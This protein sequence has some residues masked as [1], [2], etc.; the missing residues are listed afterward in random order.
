M[1]RKKRRLNVE[2]LSTREMTDILRRLLGKKGEVADVVRA[3]MERC[4]TE[5]APDAVAADVHVEL[6]RLDVEE[7]W[8]RSGRSRYGYT[9]PAEA[10]W[11][12]IEEV[13][14]P[15]IDRIRDYHETGKKKECDRY[16]LGVLKG[17]YDF[18]KKSRTEFKSQTSPDDPMEGFCIVLEKWKELRPEKDACGWMQQMLEESCPACPVDVSG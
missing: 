13:L 11:E 9:H 15:H 17:I 8:N 16:T 2:D 4:F 1:S 6:E 7:L 3:E 14:E 5:V 12:M 10:A 18:D